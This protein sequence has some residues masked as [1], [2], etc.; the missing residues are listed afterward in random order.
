[1]FVAV[2]RS[3]P[4][5]PSLSAPAVMPSSQPSRSMRATRASGRKPADRAQ[6]AENASEAAPESKAADG[7]P[8][9]G[10]GSTGVGGVAK[11][12]QEIPLRKGRGHPRKV[13]CLT[14]DGSVKIHLQLQGSLVGTTACCSAA[15]GC[16]WH[17]L[18]CL[19]SCSTGNDRCKYWV[20]GG[21]ALQRSCR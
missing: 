19:G 8:D 21:G 5:K 13:G 1:M 2:P 20:F 7:A 16:N 15:L 3:Q 9:S 17:E 14:F 6:Q 4:R 12:P 10:R 18:P 11:V